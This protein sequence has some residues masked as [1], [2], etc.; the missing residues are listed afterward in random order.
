M[1]SIFSCSHYWHMST[2]VWDSWPLLVFK[3]SR[4]SIL[5]SPI[6]HS[7]IPRLHWL[8]PK[9]LRLPKIFGLLTFPVFRVY[10]YFDIRK[11]FETQS[12]F[13]CFGLLQKPYQNY[14][15]NQKFQHLSK[16]SKIYRNFWKC[17]KFAVYFWHFRPSCTWL[18][19][20]THSKNALKT[21]LARTGAKKNSFLGFLSV[22]VPIRLVKSVKKWSKMA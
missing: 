14:R 1:V 10:R 18:A 19:K 16:M 2:A 3:T 13:F 15:N 5:R 4:P 17:W 6:L 9:V 8:W 11:S 7:L 12:S 22:F 21:V 20:Y